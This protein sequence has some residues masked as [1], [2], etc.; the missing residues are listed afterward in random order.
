VDDEDQEAAMPNRLEQIVDVALPR[1]AYLEAEAWAAIDANA[2]RLRAA[3]AAD[4]RPLAV[5]CCKELVESI[6]R[7]IL[8]ARGEA[9]GD[10]EEFTKVVS[11]AHRQIEYQEG[12]DLPLNSYVRDASSQAK[13]LALL[14]R[15][16]RNESGTGHGRA[17]VPNVADE[18]V[19]MCLAG[20][21]LW[22]RWAL[23]RIGHYIVG[24]VERLVHDLEYSTFRRGVLRDRLRSATMSRLE[25]AERRRLGIAV[26]RRTAGNTFVVC[27]DG[28]E[29]CI[30]EQDPVAWPLSYRIGVIEGLFIDS[31]GQLPLMLTTPRYTAELCAAYGDM[32]PALVGLQILLEDASWS[33]EFT[34]SW[35][36][37]VAEFTVVEPSFRNGERNAWL[38]IKADLTRIGTEYESR[39]Q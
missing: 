35:R 39:G 9:A 18:V 1:P 36:A 29:A 30:A 34:R 19:E 3:V 10:S 25:P 17:F 27:E 37:V 24:D 16:F 31:R 8:D 14:L 11:A 13:K 21:L 4:D 6:A 7:V 26:G 38:A 28:V 5:G 12:S 2:D 22:S 20:A 15:E 33:A 23:R 32:G